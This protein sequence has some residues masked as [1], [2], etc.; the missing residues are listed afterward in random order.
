MSNGGGRGGVDPA[1]AGPGLNATG[2]AE[3]GEY[4]KNRGST[5][6][7]GGCCREGSTY[8]CGTV[9]ADEGGEFSGTYSVE[10]GK[11]VGTFMGKVEEGI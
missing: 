1:L 3:V 9:H 4:D 2:P 7:P 5:D 8:P 10:L 6:G 11:Y